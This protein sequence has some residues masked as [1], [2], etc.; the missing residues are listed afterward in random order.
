[1][2]SDSEIVSESHDANWRGSASEMSQLD[3]FT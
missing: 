2:V 3:V 1:M